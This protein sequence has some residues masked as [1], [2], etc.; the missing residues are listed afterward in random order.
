ML[1]GA[2][3]LSSVQFV[4]WKN[5]LLPAIEVLKSELLEKKVILMG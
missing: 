3:L 2:L 4:T 5:A 1:A